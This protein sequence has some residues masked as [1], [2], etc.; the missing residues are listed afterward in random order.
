MDQLRD[1]V[2]NGKPVT[3]RLLNYRKDGTPFWNLLTMT[4]IKD[5]SGR[6]VKFVGVQV[7]VTASTEGHAAER[8]SAG[9]PVLINYDDRLKENVVKPIVDDVLHAV[10]QDDGREPKRLSRTGG[11]P[12]SPRSLPRVALDLATTVERIQ[13]V[14]PWLAYTAAEQFQNNFKSLK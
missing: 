7:D 1:S 10:Q 14:R 12:N 4:P 2:R 9:I 3:V 5:E 8:D 13:S 11:G 6:V